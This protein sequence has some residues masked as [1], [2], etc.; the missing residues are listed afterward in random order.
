MSTINNLFEKLACRRQLFS[1]ELIV[2]CLKLHIETETKL[3]LVPSKKVKKPLKKTGRCYPF[4]SN[5]K[6][7]LV[8]AS[9]SYSGQDYKL[10]G[11][12]YYLS[13][14]LQK[15]KASIHKRTLNTV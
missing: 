12:D 3:R 14:L 15:I 9:S 1:L 5:M 6:S 7:L 4:V 13:I 2:R 11:V 10:N 8:Q